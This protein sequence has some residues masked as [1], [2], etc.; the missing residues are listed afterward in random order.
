ME[1]FLCGIELNEPRGATG[2]ISR[3]RAF[4]PNCK[5]AMSR[6]T[7]N[8]SVPDSLL[9]SRRRVG[10]GVRYLNEREACKELRCCPKTLRR[11]RQES[12][13]CLGAKDNQAISPHGRRYLYP[14][15]RIRALIET[16][17]TLDQVRDKLILKYGLSP[18][19]TS[20][21]EA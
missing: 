21:S 3:F 14:A 15:D 11:R 6:P 5:I 2:R 13:D 16:P 17:Q 12:S 4:R 20:K 8:T 19:C 7:R 18:N 10:D 9:R 1:L